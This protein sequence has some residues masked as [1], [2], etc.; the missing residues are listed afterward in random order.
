MANYPLTKMNKEGTLLHPQRSYYSD[1]CAQVMC[2]LYLSDEIIKDEK[3]NLHTRYRLN[4]KQPHN[5]EMALA[6]DL[7]CPK[8]NSRLKQVGRTLTSHELGQ[9]VC[10]VCD[11]R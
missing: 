6:Y 9:Y 4:A 5:I 8:C 3:G 2:D 10:P 11:K 7:M 1:E